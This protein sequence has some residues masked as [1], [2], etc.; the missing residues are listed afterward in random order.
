[1]S[2]HRQFSLVQI[3]LVKQS[4][5]LEAVAWGRVVPVMGHG[6]FNPTYSQY[7]CTKNVISQLYAYTDGIMP[8]VNARDQFRG[9]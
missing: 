5:P 1:M 2:R 4:T 3:Y 6:W 7:G 9:S 8:D